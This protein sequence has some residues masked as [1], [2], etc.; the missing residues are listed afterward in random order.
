MNQGIIA[1]SANTF[2]AT[3]IGGEETNGEEKS[4]RNDYIGD[5]DRAYDLEKGP[6]AVLTRYKGK[7]AL[8]GGQKNKLKMLKD[9][10]S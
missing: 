8:T 7:S 3:G 1:E 2:Q 5:K 4:P 6:L 10:R 9:I